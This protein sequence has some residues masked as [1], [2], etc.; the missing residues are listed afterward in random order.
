M[1]YYHGVIRLRK[2][3]LFAALAAVIALVL[4]ACSGSSDDSSDSGDFTP[5]TID[6]QYGSTTIESAPT[7]V[8][9]MFPTWTDTLA[10]L[11]IPIEA[12]FVS[13]GYSGKDN[14]FP[15]TPEHDAEIIPISGDFPGAVTTAQLAAL[16]PDLILAGYTGDEETYQRFN[17]V[18]P[19]IPVVTPDAILDSWQVVAEQ[20]GKIFGKE[21]A[22]TDL[23]D[24]T[25]QNIAEFKAEFPNTQGKT[26]TYA[27]IRPDG[28]LGVVASNTDPTA[29]LQEDLGFV[30]NPAIVEANTDGAARM[31]ISSER[32]DLLDSDMLIAWTMGDE[33][34][35]ERIPGWDNLTAVENGSV[36]FVTNDDSQGFT[37]PSAPSV[38]WV[39]EQISKIAPTIE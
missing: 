32:V 27:Q 24:Q 11:D 6:H 25:N 21:Q 1:P 38:D 5:V 39:I 36:I 33:S 8:V 31:A 20:T 22:A 35:V 14:R 13:E 9:T 4:A 30:L 16:E 12:T 7:R 10:A 29:K 23:I 18:A 17:S 37:S 26:F 28:Q 19:T 3:S 2:L 34:S 15:W